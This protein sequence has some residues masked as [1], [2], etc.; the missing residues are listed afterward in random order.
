MSSTDGAPDD[1]DLHGPADPEERNP[2]S[3]RATA[4]L[5]GGIVVVIVVVALILYL[6]AG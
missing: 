1:R 2:R 5:V 4:L 3:V 6:V